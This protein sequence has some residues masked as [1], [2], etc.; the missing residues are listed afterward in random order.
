MPW[1]KYEYQ[2]LPMGLCNSPDIFQEYMG[3]LLG[4]LEHVRAYIDD[5]LIISKGTYEDH[6]QK[7]DEVFERL[8]KAGV[9]VNAVKSAFGKTKL[10]YLGY[11]ITRQGVQSMPN[12]VKAIHNIATPKTRKQL[13][14]FI[15]LVNYYCDMGVHRSDLLAPLSKLTSSS[16]NG[17]GPKLNKKPLKT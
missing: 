1:G 6:L 17:S 11:W 12:K 7:L 14:S 3:E 4:D 15:G 9:K 2:R 5:L 8:Q 13:R 10:E 16:A